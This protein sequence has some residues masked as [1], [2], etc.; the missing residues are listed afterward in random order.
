MSDEALLTDTLIKV[1]GER[2]LSFSLGSPIASGKI[3]PNLSGQVDAL[4]FYIH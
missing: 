3:A 2:M 1:P 4:E